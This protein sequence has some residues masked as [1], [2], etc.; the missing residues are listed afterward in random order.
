MVLFSLAVM[1]L[2]PEVR[3][4]VFGTIARLL[5]VDGANPEETA[6]LQKAA[7]KGWELLEACQVVPISILEQYPSGQETSVQS[8]SGLSFPPS[9]TAMV[10][11]YD[12][13]SVLFSDWIVI[14]S[15]S[16]VFSC[17]P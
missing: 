6:V 2:S 11:A 7:M 17:R 8:S 10:R 14:L 5:S 16:V 4:A 12:N 9:S 13:S 15:N 1:P 3:G